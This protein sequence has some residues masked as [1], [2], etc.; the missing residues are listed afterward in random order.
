MKIKIISYG[1]KFYEEQGLTPPKHDFLFNLRD[2]NNPF[3]VPELKPFCGRDK[4]IQD[5]FAKDEAAQSRL[6]MIT[7]L[8]KDFIDDFLSNPFRQE[9]DEIVFAFRCTGGKHRSVYFAEKLYQALE[10]TFRERLNL[11]VDHVDLQRHAV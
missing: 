1:Y 2:L 5:F 3:W 9:A 11:E 7:S 8:A 4:L 10:P 6:S